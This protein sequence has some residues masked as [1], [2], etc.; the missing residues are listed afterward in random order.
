MAGTETG[1]GAG[2]AELVAAVRAGEAD[3]ALDLYRRHL[4]ALRSTVRGRVGADLV[5]EVVQEA[6][7][8]AL[9]RLP[10][11]RQPDRFRSWLLAIGRNTANDRW[12][13]ERRQV[14]QDPE[15]FGSVSSP[16][17]PPDET[18]TMYSLVDLIERSLLRLSH[19][20]ARALALVSHLDL[21][22]TELGTALGLSPGAAKVAVHRA[23]R[24]LRAALALDLL[25][26]V[27][28]L[29]CVDHPGRDAGDREA[30]RHVEGCA[31]CLDATRAHLADL[32]A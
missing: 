31:A 3:A 2:D 30:T 6:F 4:P 5:E 9:E 16:G 12:R 14:A 15:L 20:D 8:R 23:R 1:A 17:A 11:L 32:A 21:A 25:G 26:D 7:T 18:A 19:R 24:R 10:H 13:L 29:A 28:G 22:P 27:A